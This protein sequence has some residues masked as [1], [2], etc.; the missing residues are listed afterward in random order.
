M[1]APRIRVLTKNS[2]LAINT[3]KKDGDV[4]SSSK[5]IE[6]DSDYW[7][8]SQLEIQLLG[9]P[10]I[11]KPPASKT[12]KSASNCCLCSSVAIGKLR[13]KTLTGVDVGS[14]RLVASL[15]SFSELNL[16]W[17]W[18]RAGLPVYIGL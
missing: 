15:A 14:L 3:H 18:K 8:Y 1:K 17:N 16:S 7:A 9:L 6:P 12:R 4:K 2:S 5:P 11:R 10:R 13:V